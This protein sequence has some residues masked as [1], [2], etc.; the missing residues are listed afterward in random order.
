MPARNIV[1]TAGDPCGI[2]PEVIL[3]TLCRYKTSSDIRLTV[4]GDARVFAQAALKL[5]LRFPAWVNFL[6]CG[7]RTRFI[8]GQ[9]STASGGAA[10]AYLKKALGLWKQG[11]LDALVTAPVTKW[12]IQKTLPSFVGHTEWLAKA[13]RTKQGVMLFA[14]DKLRVAVLTRHIPLRDVSK[15]VTR[16][17]L[18][19]TV[20]LCKHA[21]RAQFGIRQPRMALLGINPHAGENNAASEEHSVMQPVLRQLNRQGIQ[22]DGPFAADGFFA[23]PVLHDLVLS[24]YHDQ[25]LVAFKMAARERGCQVTIGLPFVRTSPDHGSALD[26]AGK[27][28]AN[29][30]SMRYALGLAIK[31]CSLPPR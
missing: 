16:R 23:K 22:I 26:I 27:G 30:G 19:T 4:V 29:C 13:T 12:A 11:R 24:P 9:A 28:V 2:G 21:L 25:G 8:P 31:L 5:K 6:D 15:A 1:I 20:L 10:L 17:L 18:H 3:K 14:S 7:H